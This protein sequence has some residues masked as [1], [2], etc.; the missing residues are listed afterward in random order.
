MTSSSLRSSD[1]AN[2]GSGLRFS[3]SSGVQA[4]CCSSRGQPTAAWPA[5]LRGLASGAACRSLRP[6]PLARAA[7]YEETLRPA[8]SRLRS[9][10][11]ATMESDGMCVT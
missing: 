8:G 9:L 11:P 2:A 6:R 4:A 1:H 7:A 10:F 3:N 5:L